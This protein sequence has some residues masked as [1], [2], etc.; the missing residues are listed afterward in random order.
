MSIIGEEELREVVEVVWMTALDL[1]VEEDHCVDCASENS[2]LVQIS[3]TGEWQGM[4]SVLADKE[5]LTHAASVMFSCPIADVTDVDRTD[6]LAELTNMLGGTVKCLLPEGCDLSLPVILN[7]INADAQQL[8][9]VGFSCDGMP[10]AVAIS[11]MTDDL[12]KVA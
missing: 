6:A 12:Q 1:G 8:D 3:I 11:E 10:L 4:V 5:L 2:I 9:W 7:E